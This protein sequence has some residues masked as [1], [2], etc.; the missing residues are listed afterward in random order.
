MRISRG[1]FCAAVLVVAGVLSATRVLSQSHPPPP[2][3]VPANASRITADVLELREAASSITVK[4]RTAVPESEELQH[5]ARVGSVLNAVYSGSLP[6]DLKRRTIRA[7]L[8]LTGD[9]RRVRWV[10]SNIQLAE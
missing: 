6:A 1:L 4:I 9:T 2:A 7:T 10:I 5:L 3:P 8:T